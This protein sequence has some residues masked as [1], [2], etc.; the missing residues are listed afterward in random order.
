M[1]LEQLAR[2]GGHLEANHPEA[3]LLE[4]RN[5]LADEAT[6]DAVRPGRRKSEIPASAHVEYMRWENNWKQSKGTTDHR[7]SDG[8]YQR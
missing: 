4:A 2:R 6:L 1:L 8:G 3:L 5:D 7:M